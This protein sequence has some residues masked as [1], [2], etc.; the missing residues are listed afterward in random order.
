MQKLD[1]EIT[2]KE[3]FKTKFEWYKNNWHKFVKIK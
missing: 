1:L 2:S 3:D